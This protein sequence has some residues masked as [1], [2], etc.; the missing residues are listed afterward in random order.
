M[1]NNEDI[2][3]GSSI[4]KIVK[5][6][7]VYLTISILGKGITFLLLPIYTRYLSPA[8]YGIFSTIMSTG[9]LLSLFM[10]LRLDAA[11]GRYYFEYN[12]NPE[13]LRNLFSSCFLFVLALGLVVYFLSLILG[14]VYYHRIIQIQFFPLIFLGF[15]IPLLSQITLL[16]T[17][18]YQQ[19][20]QS[21]IVGGVQIV[22]LVVINILTVLLLMTTNMKINALI[23]P[24]CI[25][26]FITC[27][28]YIVLNV[29]K[30]LLALKFD[31]S[32]LFNILP[33][34]L[35]II[36][37]ELANWVNNLS[38]RILLSIYGPVSETGLYS[39]G[40]EI[41]K[42]LS[43]V[44][45]AIGMVYTPIMYARLSE[46]Y[47][48]AI[49]SLR[50]PILGLFWLMAGLAFFACIFAKDILSM[51]AGK[52]FQGAST[53]LVIIIFT[54]FLGGQ[55]ILF[56]N[57]LGYRKKMLLLSSISIISAILSLT[58]NIIFIPMYGKM[59]AAWTTFASVLFYSLLVIYFGYRESR[60][61]IDWSGMFKVCIVILTMLLLYNLL[62]Y[63]GPSKLIFI[64]KLLL[65][66][67]S[68]I[69]TIILKIFGSY[70]ASPFS[71]AF[72]RSF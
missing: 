4:Y 47:T 23:I 66:P 14:Y 20:H 70:K 54:Y 40:Y 39:I 6:G 52:E 3:A 2:G 5:H 18:Y 7:S 68:I 15:L 8:D 43:L 41:G 25:G 28:Y 57:I 30:G 65:I 34:S 1:K 72:W 22:S 16:S 42:G 49:Q 21:K 55:Y 62:E 69:L 59:A 38:D 11:F 63:C 32:I 71:P 35:A 60:P 29:K 17:L 64:G 33:F 19:T 45:M 37:G 48:A 9:A 53:V 58:S 61:E 56:A 10:S 44:T 51:F 31:R 26:A 24:A 27:V 12:S 67:L 46:N 50:K 13:E 36:P